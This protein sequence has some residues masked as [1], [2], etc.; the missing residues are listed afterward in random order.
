MITI[1][2]SVLNTPSKKN[3]K[4]SHAKVAMTTPSQS[5]KGQSKR[6][7]TAT[8]ALTEAPTGPYS[9]GNFASLAGG[10]SM[11]IVIPDSANNNN[12]SMDK[13]TDEDEHMQPMMDVA[14][15]PGTQGTALYHHQR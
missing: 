1:D 10:L 8:T 7:N 11:K 13:N 15:Y 3:T 9:Q 6:K 12:C 5:K 14:Q 2:P 4:A